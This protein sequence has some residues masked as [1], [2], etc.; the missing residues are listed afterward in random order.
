MAEAEVARQFE[1]SAPRLFAQWIS[2]RPERL[3][4]SAVG[5]YI[6][7]GAMR[8]YYCFEFFFCEDTATP[9]EYSIDVRKTDSVLTP[10]IGV[11]IVPTHMT[12][13]IQALSAGLKRSTADRLA[14]SCIDHTYD[15]CLAAGAK[16]PSK[17]G[18]MYGPCSQT[19][20]G[21]TFT[22]EDEAR[23]SYAWRQGKWEFKSVEQKKPAH[24]G[25]KT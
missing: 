9:S 3:K 25:K 16:V 24:P 10:F 6:G 15:S 22:F 11:L 7:E 17:A 12:C 20:V 23:V 14:A 4:A 18:A 5:S 2:E 21:H 13:T 1:Q 8:N 19:A